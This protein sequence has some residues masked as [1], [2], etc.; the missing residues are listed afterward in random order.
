MTVAVFVLVPVLTEARTLQVPFFTPFKVAPT[1][2]QFAEPEVTRN[3][4]FAVLATASFPP[5][6]TVF[7]EI[8][9]FTFTLAF[10]ATVGA[11]VVVAD[12]G[13]LTLETSATR[14]LANVSAVLVSLE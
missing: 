4:T 5:T 9:R 10:F 12:A 3:V 1:T 14:A 7:A 8:V 6:A 11:T 2:L 13:R